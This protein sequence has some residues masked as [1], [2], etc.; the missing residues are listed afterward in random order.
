[1]KTLALTAIIVM[2]LVFASAQNGHGSE[3][4]SRDRT[5]AQWQYAEYAETTFDNGRQRYSIN[6]ANHSLSLDGTR[7]D[8]LIRLGVQ[9]GQQNYHER[10]LWDW[11]GDQGWEMISH[12]QEVRSNRSVLKTRF[13]RALQ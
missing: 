1:M 2:T 10:I 4:T 5:A 12:H 3:S 8:F 6:S 13:K 7:T 9:R 11:M